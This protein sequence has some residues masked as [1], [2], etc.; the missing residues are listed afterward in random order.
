MTE[1]LKPSRVNLKNICI[2]KNRAC[3]NW[4]ALLFSS[5]THS[6]LPLYF[7]NYET[8]YGWDDCCRSDG[9]SVRPVLA[10]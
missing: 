1:A 5:G 4:R 10:Q 3:H 7:Y 9:Y 8:S 2:Y 6:A